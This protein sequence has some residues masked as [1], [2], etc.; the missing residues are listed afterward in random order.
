LGV[1]QCGLLIA[2]TAARNFTESHRV[3]TFIAANSRRALPAMLLVAALLSA[4][5]D[6]HP[7]DGGGTLTAA[8]ELRLRAV[9]A[10]AQ[11]LAQGVVAAVAGHVTPAGDELGAAG[12]D[13]PGGKTLFA[14][15]ADAKAMTAVIAARL[16]ERGLIRWDTRIAEAL[17]ELRREMLPAYRGATL[18]DLLAHRA[19]LPPFTAREE[20]RRFL[21]LLPS[22]PDAQ[23]ASDSGRRLFFARWLLQQPPAADT[24]FLYSNAGY[25]LAATM[26]ERASGQNYHA[27]F[28]QEV[29]RPLGIAGAWREA[30]STDATGAGSL[31]LW[32]EALVPASLYATT[33]ST[34]ASWLRWHLRAL[35]GEATPLPSGY[36]RRLRDLVPGGYAFGWTGAM[37][38][39]RPVLQHARGTD[40]G[41]A[42]AQ[43]DAVID[44]AGQSAN[45]A[46]ARL[47]QG[48]DASDGGSRASALLDRLLASRDAAAP[49]A[50]AA[51]PF[52]AHWRCRLAGCS[53]VMRLRRSGLFRA[54]L[55]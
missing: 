3:T 15:D 33:P 7:D 28:E 23:L 44:A 34:Y 50:T 52:L 46:L 42:G 12:P 37:R 16:V 26:L 8:A 45:F 13:G 47:A 49:A 43:A 54:L 6:N 55:R 1:E 31:R 35:Q 9:S 5:G 14:I 39:G 21:G 24:G 19:G 30:G 36:V 40:S 51:V 18:D 11:G 22:H 25:A 20:F 48:G 2:P 53:F 17:P 41:L 27:L 32:R 10:A 38:N 29:A 4:C